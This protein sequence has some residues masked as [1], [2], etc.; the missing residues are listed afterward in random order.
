MLSRDLSLF[1]QG[2]HGSPRTSLDVAKFSAHV[3]IP[4]AAACC[5]RRSSSSRRPTATKLLS[6]VL[7]SLASGGLGIDRG[8]GA[9]VISDV[10]GAPSTSATLV[11]APPVDDALRRDKKRLLRSKWKYA[12]ELNWWGLQPWNG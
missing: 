7:S 5:S 1:I 6:F 8:P 11:P 10:R 12:R 9:G 4:H 2:R 3:S